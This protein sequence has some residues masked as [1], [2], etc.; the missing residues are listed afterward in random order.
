M[1]VDTTATF[2][3]VM[4][5]RTQWVKLLSLCARNHVRLGIP[6]VVLRETARHWEERATKALDAAVEAHNKLV[7]SGRTF[8][9]LGL[10]EVSRPP[11]LPEVTISTKAFFEDQVERLSSL[12]VEV[13]PLPKVS[14]GD[15][16]ER[17]LARQ[18]PFSNS[19]KGFRDALIWHSVKEL[20][21]SLPMPSRLYFVSDNVGDFCLD[22]EFDPDLLRE[23]ESLGRNFQHLRTVADLFETEPVRAL[24]AEIE[25]T[26]EELAEFL[27]RRIEE[28]ELEP[29]EEI[30]ISELVSSAVEAAVVDLHGEEIA[31]RDAD[32]GPGLDFN[33]I[34]IPVELES[35]TIAYVETH[36][37]SID[38]DIYETYE[39]ETLLIRATVDADIEIEGF[40][41]KGD[42]YAMEDEFNL[43][44]SDWNDYYVQAS[45]SLSARLAFQLRV[46]S[47]AGLVEHTDFES[48]E[49]L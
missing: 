32:V 40:V 22:E 38:W 42:Y 26:D 15:L 1:V 27:R 44:D 30:S 18:K 10:G 46:E 35:P 9:Y 13:L 34:E 16:L 2:D 12:G 14:V 36:P 5:S 23:I 49:P 21:A 39:E 31:S 20:L 6:T 7:K 24:V 29:Y 41:Y 47:G 11:D 45:I 19:G 3:D 48:A 8:G 25:A 33:E 17:D 28:A 37:K 43:L 4:L